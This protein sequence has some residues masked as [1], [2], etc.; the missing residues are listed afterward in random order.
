MAKSI[1]PLNGHNN[2][3]SSNV[4]PIIL[5]WNQMFNKPFYEYIYL[6]LG[7][8]NC[9]YECVYT[10]DK[11]FESSA[12]VVLFHVRQDF[13][14]FPE[15][16]RPEQLYTMMSVE[17]PHWTK[18]WLMARL[19]NN[20]FN[21]SITYHTDSTIY[22]PYDQLSA[23]T[24]QT[25]REQIWSDREIQLQINLKQRLALQIVSHCGAP[26]GRDS[27]T[28]QLQ[29]L[30]ELDVLG[31]CN[32]K[33]CD[34][35]CYQRELESHF[36][37]LAFENT[38]CPQYVT[39]K[40]WNALRSLVVPVVLNRSMLNG[41]GIPDNVYIAADDFDS[42]QALAHFLTAL[43]GDSEKYL[44][45]FNWTKKYRR[46]WDNTTPSALCQLCQ[47]A[48]KQMQKDKDGIQTS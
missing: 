3:K 41:T 34:D 17:S 43:L 46:Q 19:P 5:G 12:S 21:I 45:Y 36:F 10:E 31:G 1:Q 2:D 20:Y 28:E 29:N 30:M 8:N 4:R 22:L 33:S 6:K 37:Y 35:A 38:V 13:R 15:H 24:S 9:S 44:S 7:L 40:F 11:T 42:V 25:P 39:E 16:R 14:P 18:W 27:I 32:S 47:I 23:I 26:S 48:H